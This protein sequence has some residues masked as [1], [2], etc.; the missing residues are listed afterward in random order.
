MT[1]RPRDAATSSAPGEEAFPEARQRGFGRVGRRVDR[2]VARLPGELQKQRGLADLPGSGAELDA[3]RCRLGEALP[4]HVPALVI[5][6][7]EVSRWHGRIIIRLRSRTQEAGLGAMP[8]ASPRPWAR[9]A[10]GRR[11]RTLD[12]HR[13][14]EWSRERGRCRAAEPRGL[15]ARLRATTACRTA[16]TRRSQGHR[17]ALG[18]FRAS[19]PP[20]AYRS[21]ARGSRA[22]RCGSTRA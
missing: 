2:L 22:R 7:P 6:E 15:G 17:E 3:A 10:S 21:R 8:G 5:T 9:A 4:Q 18:V 20:A 13:A 1:A 12:E 19:E 11:N 16:V 14:V